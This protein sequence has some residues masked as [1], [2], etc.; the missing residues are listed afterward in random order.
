MDINEMNQMYESL[1]SDGKSGNLR[2]KRNKR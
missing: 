2:Q 1:A